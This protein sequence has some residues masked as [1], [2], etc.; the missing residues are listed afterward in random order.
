[1]LE[2]QLQTNPYDGNGQSHLCGKAPNRDRPQHDHDMEAIQPK[3]NENAHELTTLCHHTENA[4]NLNHSGEKGTP[5]HIVTGSID[6]QE[7]KAALDGLN[8]K[9]DT[10]QCRA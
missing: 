2:L 7:L 3:T 1:M 10:G 5:C 4:A 6:L 8:P 9:S